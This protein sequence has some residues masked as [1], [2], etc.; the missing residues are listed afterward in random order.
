MFSGYG[1]PILPPGAPT[2]MDECLMNE[3][4]EKEPKPNLI[5]RFF[6]WIARI[7]RSAG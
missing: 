1:P 7:L 5:K 6:R 4:P 3:G 2:L